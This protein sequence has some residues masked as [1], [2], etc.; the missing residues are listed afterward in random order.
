V[1][2]I[3]TRI[4]E[5]AQKRPDTQ[6]LVFAGEHHESITW[7]EL[8]DLID[9]LAEVFKTTSPHQLIALNLPNSPALIV[10]FLAIARAEREAAICDPAWPN[11]QRNAIFKQLRPSM[12]ITCDQDKAFE[13]TTHILPESA[14]NFSGIK[15]YFSEEKSHKIHEEKSSSSL[16]YCG[17]TSGSTGIPKGFRR[18]HAS[19]LAS[20]ASGDE[21][22]DI[23][24][25]DTIL[26]LGILT[27]SLHLYAIVHALHTGAK[28]VFTPH[29]H[30]VKIAKTIVKEAISV[31]YGTPTQLESLA[32]T[33]SKTP[34]MG[35]RKILSS[36][37][38]LSLNQRE[39]LKRAYPQTHIDEF[40]GASELSFVTVAKESENVPHNSVG[41][42]M[43]GVTLTIRDVMGQGVQTGQEG[44]VCV[45]SDLIFSSYLNPADDR[46]LRFGN[47][48]SV[49]DRGIIDEKGFLYL[50]GRFERLI[51]VGGRNIAPEGIE[52]TLLM[53]PAIQTAAVMGIMDEKRGERLVAVIA[54]R[55]GYSLN[56]Q[57]IVAHVRSYHPEYE[58]PQVFLKCCD[59]PR[60]ISGK[61]DFKRLKK[62]V[63][64]GMFLTV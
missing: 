13:H 53:H 4:R 9:Q 31:I 51:I 28:A 62:D 3:T 43:K 20:F 34:A 16:F 39:Y 23:T 60:L 44:F 14:L 17:F 64:Q 21:T 7:R 33:Q 6:A 42:A 57:D 18:N 47:A 63:E 2:N 8:D 5:H 25:N 50:T 27:H 40:Y 46:L 55:D 38:K 1:H 29:F 54:L 26:A 41:R 37:D 36:G 35:M 15:E 45:E 11:T 10:C 58:V 22:F 24:A 61:T 48:I 12:M 49:G 52:K 30:P 32:L 56:R 59:W 19:W